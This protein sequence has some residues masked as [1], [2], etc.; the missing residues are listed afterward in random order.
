MGLYAASNICKFTPPPFADFR[1]EIVPNST[2]IQDY[3]LWVRRL[4]NPE[5]NRLLRRCTELYCEIKEKQTYCVANEVL[6]L[7]LV[8]TRLKKKEM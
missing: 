4:G 8:P 1:V 2:H 7:V 3:P 6:V 5:R